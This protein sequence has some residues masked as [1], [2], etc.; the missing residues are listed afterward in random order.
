MKERP[1]HHL[2]SLVQYNDQVDQWSTNM[3]FG[4][5]GTAGTGLFLVFNT[6]EGV[7]DLSGPLN[8]SVI[9]KYSR[10]FNVGGD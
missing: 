5:L 4:W 9:L 7:D 10:Q 8:R 6:Q 2:Q 3:R 1:R